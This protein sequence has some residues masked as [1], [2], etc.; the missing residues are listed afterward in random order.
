MTISQGPP[1]GLDEA[2]P[3]R[4]SLIIAHVVE[5]LGGGVASDH[6]EC[7]GAVFRLSPGY[8][9]GAAQPSAD[10]VAK[11]LQGGSRPHGRW[12]DN[13]TVK[14]PVLIYAPDR[15]TLVAARE[16]LARLCDTEQF[17]LR[18]TRGLPHLPPPPPSGLPPD[19]VAEEPVPPGAMILDCFRAGPSVPAYSV[20]TEREN[21][22]NVEI[23]F[24]ALPYGKS[25]DRETVWFPT[26][27]IGGEVA[28]PTYADWRSVDDFAGAPA[29][30]TQP[31]SWD[32]FD[33]GAAVWRYSAHW[34]PLAHRTAQEGDY[35]DYTHQFAVPVDV[36]GRGQMN[37][38]VG[39]GNSIGSWRGGNL[40]FRMTLWDSGENWM[41]FGGTFRLKGTDKWNRPNFSRVELPWPRGTGFN[42][43]ELRRYRVEVPNFTA[44]AKMG[45]LF[46]NCMGAAP[47]AIP[48]IPPGRRDQV[49]TISA[50]G[51]ARTPVSLR[52]QPP[53]GKYAQ[54]FVAT[55]PGPG[56][57]PVPAGTVT[58]PDGTPNAARVRLWA[59]G[60][61]GGSVSNSNGRMGGGSG[62]NCCG[63]DHY[64]V[65]PGTP[66]TF[67]LTDSPN[68]STALPRPN[69]AANSTFGA[70][71]P[72]QLVARAG[73]CGETNNWHGASPQAAPAPPAGLGDYFH[74]LGGWGAYARDPGQPNQGA[75]GGGGGAGTSGPG[76]EAPGQPGGAGGPGGG[77]HGGGGQS[78]FANG[79]GSIGGGPSGG[80]G[81]A[82]RLTPNGTQLASKGAPGK[83]LVEWLTAVTPM[84]TLVAHMPG[85]GHGPS[86]VPCVPLGNGNVAG[87]GTR[88]V[89]RAPAASATIPIPPL[90]VRYHGTYQGILVVNTWGGSTTA[91]RD[92]WV[93]I[94]LHDRD[95]A[96]PGAVL[97]GT[98]EIGGPGA[99]AGWVPTGL[100]ML[101]D[102]G[103]IT[104]P[105]V[106]LPDD[107]Q[108]ATYSV[109]IHSNLTAGGITADR[110]MDLL[111]LDVTGQTVVIDD[112][113]PGAGVGGFADY[114]LDEPDTTT[115]YG[116]ILGSNGGRTSARSVTE[117]LVF[118]SGGPFI[119][120]AGQNLMLAYSRDGAPSLGLEY[121]ARWWFDRAD[122]LA[123]HQ[124][125]AGGGS[126][127]FG[128]AGGGEEPRGRQWR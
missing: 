20:L 23:T 30:T 56:V 2:D 98:A 92:V 11:L 71:G 54:S 62:G 9:L 15:A 103:F 87:D 101:V 80:G 45:D 69:P 79:P 53:A 50:I 39:L 104:L 6:P 12:A 42:F 123:A 1:P 44:R 51:S 31:G 34:K 83:L 37:I 118:A 94:D 70:A 14:L 33:S 125:D 8:D 64:P 63:S 16:L 108:D 116:A 13:R 93:N 72:T 41:Q 107:N 102:L 124:L 96:L 26:P 43:H 55:T 99:H 38:W 95:P 24:A 32:R 7:P 4:D 18:W 35:P 128:L 121:N 82:T 112:T 29:T 60:G 100:P 122:D 111:L 89:I 19:W 126:P 105:L 115:S 27:V 68:P 47:T 21:Y 59:P 86:F 49:Y 76:Q 117:Y 85:P 5:L 88:Y 3:E 52:F 78:P 28:P 73:Q 10:V 61:T 119:L 90:P 77:G 48:W 40:T 106:Q 120:E 46:L 84:K 25:D 81:G 91:A 113:R 114:F 110:F 75:G 58:A 74:Y 36:Y 127:F 65:T 22:A 97:L 109:R 67:V 17:E 66:I 57:W